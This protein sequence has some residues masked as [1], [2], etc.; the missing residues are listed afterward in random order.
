[1]AANSQAVMSSP[2][3]ASGWRLKSI[4][5]LRMLGTALLLL[6]VIALLGWCVS[7]LN[8]PATLPISK[9]R[10][11]G[12]FV[13][14]DEAMLQRAVAEMA[15]QGFFSVDIEAVKQRVEQLPWVAQASVRRIWP[16]TLGI[17]VQEQKAVARWANGGLVNEAGRSFT[18][19]A[20]SHPSRLPLFRGPENML[21]EIGEAYRR[22]SALL[23]NVGLRISE[24]NM[25]S[26]RALSLK[27]NQSENESFE[28]VLGREQT[29]ARLQ[30]FIR[31]YKKL[32]A[33]HITEIER[34][35]LRYSNGMSVAWKTGSHQHIHQG[36]E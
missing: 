11:Q 10:V 20:S 19:L 14:L 34:V 7:L 21:P 32:L 31:V 33:A 4:L 13:H 15:H 27:L 16:D 22:D 18:P 3:A 30:R 8:D 23:V 28:L 36:G 6:G 2:R 25:N 26:R 29:E 35:D 9:V 5:P 24:V 17:D 1:M 12:N